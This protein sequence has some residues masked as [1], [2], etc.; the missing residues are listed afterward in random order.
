MEVKKSSFRLANFLIE[1][2]TIEQKP[3]P[4]GDS[5]YDL[6][7][8]P[9][10][11]ISY[12]QNTFQ[13]M[14]DFSITAKNDSFKCNV[15][16]VGIFEFDELIKENNRNNYFYLN[17]PA[18]IFP[19]IRAYISSLTALSGMKTLN[20]PTLNLSTLKKE[21]EANTIED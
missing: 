15:V 12:E 8:A 19:Y 7:I 4:D 10:G 11:V 9:A 2:A 6:A 14:L 3:T 5:K 16:A 17:A 21:L 13:L 18:I 20:L 1:K